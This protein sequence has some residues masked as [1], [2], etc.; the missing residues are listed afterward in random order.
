M[1][2][3]KVR[4]IIRGQAVGIMGGQLCGLCFILSAV[5]SHG[6]FLL[7]GEGHVLRYNLYF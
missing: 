6:G 4:D 5:G 1:Q 2:D 3:V 7:V